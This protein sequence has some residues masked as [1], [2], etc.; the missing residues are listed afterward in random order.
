MKLPRKLRLLGHDILVERV[1]I[2]LSA[3]TT[4]GQYD[5]ESGEIRVREGLEPSIE[6]ATVLHEV[7]HVI[8]VT[9]CLSLSEDQVVGVAQGIF[10]FLADNDFM[11]RKK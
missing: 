10:A 3:S 4:L 11:Q 5:S 2:G 8:D 9:L 1:K 6:D 7:V